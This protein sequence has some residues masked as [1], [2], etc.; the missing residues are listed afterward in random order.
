MAMTAS[1]CCR[2]SLDCRKSGVLARCVVS[3][4]QLFAQ[5]LSSTAIV[6]GRWL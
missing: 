2:R 4:P 6:A 3:S 5:T 1:R